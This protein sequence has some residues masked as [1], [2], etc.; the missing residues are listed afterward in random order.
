MDS[1]RKE[2]FSSP[3]ERK[4]K[5]NDSQSGRKKE[6]LLLTSLLKNKKKRTKYGLCVWIGGNDSLLL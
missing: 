3:R 4:R 1:K 6:R 2:P 5:K